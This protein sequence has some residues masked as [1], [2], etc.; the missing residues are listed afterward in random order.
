MEMGGGSSLLS[1]FKIHSTAIISS[2]IDHDPYDPTHPV[3]TSRVPAWRGVG[4]PSESPGEGK[5]TFNNFH[6]ELNMIEMI[7]NMVM[8][9]M[10]MMIPAL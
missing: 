4:S 9:L 7:I 1:V 5:Q 8:T 10:L 6:D 3:A 2:T